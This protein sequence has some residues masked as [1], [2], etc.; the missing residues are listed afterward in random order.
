MTKVALVDDHQLIRN[1][2]A[3]LINNFEGYQVIHQA[4]D[5]GQ[6]LTQLKSYEHP[7]IALVDINMPNMDGYETAKRLTEEYPAIKILALSVEDD[8]EAIIKMLRSGSKGYLLKD[9]PT[10][11]FKLALDEINSKGYYHSDLVTNTLL[12]SLKPSKN[13]TPVKSLIQYQ[14]REE[15]FLHLACSELT[16]KEI[17]DK[18][19]VSPRTIDGYREN[20]FFKLD[21]K[22]RVGMVLF[23]I[24][25]SIVEI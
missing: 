6:F 22:S 20:L 23:A 14:A 9:T 3:E 16:Y 13:G 24:K 10:K 11:E 19:C 5:G 18:M 1:A 21:V 8:E 17:A 25:N 15:E 7:D 4:R 12:N 2:L